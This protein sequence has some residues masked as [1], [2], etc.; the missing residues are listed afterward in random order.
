M[1]ASRWGFLAMAAVAFLSS[2]TPP[3]PAGM[4]DVRFG[5][6]HTLSIGSRTLTYEYDSIG[7]ISS[8]T[9]K[10]GDALISTRNYQWLS[11]TPPMSVIDILTVVTPPSTTTTT[12]RLNPDGLAEQKTDASGTTTFKYDPGAELWNHSQD[13]AGDYDDRT[14]NQ[15]GDIYQED[16]T[17]GNGNP[18][19]VG[20]TITQYDLSAPNYDDG[21]SFLGSSNAHMPL[22]QTQS[23]GESFT[24]VNTLG[25]DGRVSQQMRT[26][27][28]GTVTTFFTY[29]PN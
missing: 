18:R 17:D 14:I 6:L 13:P 27:A 16:Q 28:N 25:P 29:Y 19:G 20:T 10:D 15:D 4:K 11:A 9:T 23:L 12:W 3:P 7:R 2:C 22:S 1:R 8:I 5:K 26:S 24:F 21:R